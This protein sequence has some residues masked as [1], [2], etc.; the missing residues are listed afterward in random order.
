MRKTAFFAVLLPFATAAFGQVP[1]VPPSKAGFPMTLAGQGS[2]SSKPALVDMRIP[3]DTVG[4]KSIV[5]VGSNGNLH[6]IHR[7]SPTTW[8]EAPGFPVQVSPSGAAPTMLSSPAVG[9][10]TGD[11]VPEIV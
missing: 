10:L 4:I 1:Q 5:F 8:A 2:T 9:D 6:V 7:T 3:G 11:C